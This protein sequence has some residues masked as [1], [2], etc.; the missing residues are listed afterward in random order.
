MASLLKQA[1]SNAELRQGGELRQTLRGTA[2]QD[3]L[4]PTAADSSSPRGCE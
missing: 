4:L 3:V 2:M 1:R